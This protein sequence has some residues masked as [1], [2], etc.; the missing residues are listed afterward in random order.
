M[1]LLAGLLIPACRLMMKT[2]GR[3]NK[4]CV[5]VYVYVWFFGNGNVDHLVFSSV[6]K[7][8]FFYELM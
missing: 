5:F 6:A 8:D 4:I 2:E 1:G 3:G 7:D